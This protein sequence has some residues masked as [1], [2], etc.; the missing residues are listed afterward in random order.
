M[1]K[2]IAM[3]LCAFMV[4]SFVIIPGICVTATE[5]TSEPITF[6]NG[7]LLK[8]IALAYDRQGEQVLYDQKNARRN[9]YSSPEEATAQRTIFLDCSSYVNSCYRE[10]FG[11]NILPF[12]IGEAGTSPS[13][14]NYD[15]YAKNNQSASDVVGYWVPA[16]YTTDAERQAV[17]DKIFEE[18]KIGDILT[19]RHGKPTST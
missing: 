5:N 12:E 3:F 10:A 7:E 16:D 6:T 13:T 1:K 15:E 17:V 18:I 2:F 19:Y 9:I 4:A 8:E 11:V 14:A